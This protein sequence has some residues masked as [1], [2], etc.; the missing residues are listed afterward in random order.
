MRRKNLFVVEVDVYLA[1]L[2]LG[3][4]ALQAA[5][6]VKVSDASMAGLSDALAASLAKEGPAATAQVATT[7]KF[8]RDV[9][10][11]KVVEAFNEAFA[12]CDK[13]AVDSFKKNMADTIGANGMKNGETLTF[14]WMNGGAGLAV[15]KN[16]EVGPALKAPELEKRLLEV[17][18]RPASAVSPELIKTVKEHIQCV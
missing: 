16:G 11:T 10:Q 3:T 2:Y 14:Y 5:K 15:E 8:V 4:E 7:L 18:T 13:A 17:Y 12:G 9:G 6:A 1:S